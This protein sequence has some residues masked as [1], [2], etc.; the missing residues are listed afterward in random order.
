[1]FLFPFKGLYNASA[2]LEYNVLLNA[3]TERAPHPPCWT[4]ALPV[5]AR[6]GPLQPSTTFKYRPVSQV[7][8]NCADLKKIVR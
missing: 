3:G 8:L 1:M 7:H 2:P 6:I 5:T 4:R